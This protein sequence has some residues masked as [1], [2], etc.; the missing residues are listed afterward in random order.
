[1]WTA[2]SSRVLPH[3]Y[4]KRG[5][6][7]SVPRVGCY[8]VHPVATSAPMSARMPPSVRFAFSASRKLLPPGRKLKVKPMTGKGCENYQSGMTVSP[9]DCM[10]CGVCGRLP[11]P[12]RR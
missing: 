7:V 4:E 10:G 8:K 5:V 12:A 9:L 11:A 3:A 2:S 1:M 6:A